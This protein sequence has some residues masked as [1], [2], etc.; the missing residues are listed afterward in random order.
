MLIVGATDVGKVRSANE[1]G[2]DFGIFDDGTA[3]AIVCDGMGGVRGGHIASSLVLE[4]VSEKIK[5]CYNK[6]MP[7][8]S[9]ENMFLSTITT[10]N[11]IVHDRSFTDEELK[12]MGT[13]I[14]AVIIKDHIAC[15]AHVGDSRVYKISEGTIKQIT[16][17]H[18]LAQE[19]LD[20]GQLT[21]EEFENYPKKNIITRALGVDED[22]DIDFDFTALEDG[23][24]LVL[25]SD[26]LSGLISDEDILRIYNDNSI[27]TVCE[28]YIEA[29]NGNGGHDNIT[30][31]VMKG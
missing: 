6:L 5:K 25:C 3:W 20:R 16:K 18:S 26:G 22:I 23:E 29:A 7:S 15:I 2:Y 4:M 1:D 9:F 21:Q 11:V 27:N 31:V 17:D 13:T 19:M 10:A 12:G 30:V 14:A 8:Y 28:K 24:S